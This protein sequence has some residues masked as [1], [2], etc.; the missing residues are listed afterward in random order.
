M[1]KRIQSLLIGAAIGLYM[2]LIII[3]VHILLLT[4]HGANTKKWTKSQGP[5]SCSE[6]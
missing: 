2:A 5:R 6:A 3:V 1:V 4:N